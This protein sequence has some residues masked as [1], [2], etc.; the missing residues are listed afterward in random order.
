MAVG[1]ADIGSD[2]NQEVHDVVVTSAD[3]VVERRDALVVGLAGIT[4]L[5]RRRGFE[6]NGTRA[7][8]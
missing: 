1:G 5:E 8:D 4:H 2:A 3:G 6:P 7:L